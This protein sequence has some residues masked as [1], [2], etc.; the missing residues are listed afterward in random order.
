[1]RTLTEVH[2]DIV[3]LELQIVIPLVVRVAFVVL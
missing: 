1:M 3:V 2:I